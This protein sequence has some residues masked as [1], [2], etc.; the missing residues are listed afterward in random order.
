MDCKLV[1]KITLLCVILLL[2]PIAWAVPP[3]ASEFYGYVVV[4]GKLAKPTT[5]I[6]V[7]DSGGNPCGFFIIEEKGK[8]GYMSCNGDDSSTKK[9]EG[10]IAFEE[11]YFN[12][13]GKLAVAFGNTT[14]SGGTVK[15][16][17]LV[18]GNLKRS[19]PVTGEEAPEPINKYLFSLALLLLMSPVYYILIKKIQ[20][21]LHEL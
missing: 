7:F 3:A 6:D 1:I 2:L 10:A 17:D 8:Y 18:I 13:D 4:D 12:V 9:D 14:W 20:S 15:R 16:V 11:V 5:I 19:V 21:E